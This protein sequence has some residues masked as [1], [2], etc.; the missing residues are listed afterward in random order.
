MALKSQKLKFQVVDIN[1]W[2]ARPFSF[3]FCNYFLQLIV[4]WVSPGCP[5]SYTT[6]NTERSSI[7]PSWGIKHNKTIQ[8]V[9]STCFLLFLLNLTGV[10]YSDGIIMGKIK[11]VY[12]VR[13]SKTSH[14]TDK[15]VATSWDVSQ[16]LTDVSDICS[17]V[18]TSETSVNF[19]ESTCRNVAEDLVSPPWKHNISNSNKNKAVPL[20]PCRR[21]G[22]DEVQVVLILD[23]GTKCERVV[24]VTS[25][26][27]FTPGTHCTGGWVG[28]RAGVD[29][30]ARGSNPG[31]PVCSQTLYWMSY[32]SSLKSR[33]D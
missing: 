5:V 3:K 10:V 8:W 28:P 18:I 25:R 31:R 7:A 12:H 19:Y 21:Q 16:N 23:L 15:E 30:E 6:F 20:L 22:G 4:G 9:L 1:Y 32:I 17:A 13:I 2:P 27:L 26:S 14:E 11:C 24:S 33:T 29:T